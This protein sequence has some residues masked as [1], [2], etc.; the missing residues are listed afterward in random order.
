MSKK[1][2]SKNQQSVRTNKLK[3]TKKLQK[4]P[5]TLLGRF[6]VYDQAKTPLFLIV[7]GLLLLSYSLLHSYFVWRS[8]RL[9]S[10]EVKV[11]SSQSTSKPVPTHI[12]IRW[13]VDSDIESMSLVNTEWSISPTKTSY[14]IQ[15]ARPG[16]SGNIILYGHNTREILGNIRAL[17]GNEVVSLTSSDGKTHQY[18]VTEMKETEPDDISWLQPTSTETLTMY[19]CSGL[20]DSKRFLIRAVPIEAK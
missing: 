17:K 6:F 10:D 5:S 4:R 7:I 8:L 1:V 3:Q 18:K 2:Q 11:I 9:S 15:S 16:E 12:F 13:F 14:L 20:L 19:T